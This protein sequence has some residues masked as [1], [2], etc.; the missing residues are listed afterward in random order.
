MTVATAL[1]DRP[2][3]RP[4]RRPRVLLV[5]DDASVRHAMA[6]ALRAAGHDVTAVAGA[7]QALAV[8]VSVRPDVLVT[9][10][11]MPEMDGLE[12]V[13]TLR[14]RE[15]GVPVL[16]VS[17]RDGVVD[18]VAAFEAGC[19]AFLA[20]PFGLG[21]LLARVSELTLLRV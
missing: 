9:D 4:A 14:V 15:V 6:A 11:T 2:A 16:V 3:D 5:E 1:L 10:L 19:D 7:E 20:K 8:L 13:R 18:R 12:L 21:E 17:A